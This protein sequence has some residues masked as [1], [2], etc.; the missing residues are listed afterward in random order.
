MIS[1]LTRPAPIVTPVGAKLLSAGLLIGA[2]IGVVLWFDEVDF[3]HRH[4]F[5]P[6]A[7]VGG[8]L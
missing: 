2:F 7:L 3:Y 5:E 1:G 4:F 6:G 8:I